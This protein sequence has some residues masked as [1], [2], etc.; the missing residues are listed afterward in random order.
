MT[1]TRQDND[2]TNYIGVV[3]VETKIEQLRPIKSG[4]VCYKNRSR[5][6]IDQPYKYGLHQN[7]N[8]TGMTDKTRCRLRW[9]LDKKTTWLII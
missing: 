5:Q 2:V 6:R 4:V 3:Y 9:K 1:K 7:R 8:W